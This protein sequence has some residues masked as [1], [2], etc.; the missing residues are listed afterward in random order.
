MAENKNILDKDTRLIDLTGLT[1]F[2]TNAQ[3]YINDLNTVMGGRVSALEGTVGDANN[4]LVKD[5]AGLTTRVDEHD[6]NIKDLQDS[7]QALLGEGAEGGSSISEMIGTAI[8]NF[9]TNTVTPISNKVSALEDTVNDSTNGLVKKVDDLRTDV[10]GI[11]GVVDG[12]I[13]DAIGKLT[14]NAQKGDNDYVSSITLTDG[15]LVVTYDKETNWSGD[16]EAA[17]SEAIADANDYTNDELAKHVAAL[18][19]PGETDTL[20]QSKLHIQVGER[21]AWNL[22]ADRIN[23][24][25]T[26]TETKDAIDNLTE[27]NKWFTDHEKDYNGLLTNVNN[28][29][30]AISSHNDRLA[31][32]EGVKIATGAEIIAEIFPTVTE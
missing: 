5:V 32:L 12:K 14:P 21:E 16:I 28:N 20:K 6:D 10:D 19:N 9:N 23:T 25:L 26:S 29:N 13:S 22:A 2:W 18:N 30:T 11:P 15:K 3:K 7:V 8:N 31:A 24:F 4:G 17:K 27:I 1:T